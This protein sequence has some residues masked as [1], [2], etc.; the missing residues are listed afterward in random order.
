MV[1]APFFV[2]TRKRDNPAYDRDGFRGIP[3]ILAQGNNDANDNADGIC[4]E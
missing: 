1:K 3:L 2:F 4:S